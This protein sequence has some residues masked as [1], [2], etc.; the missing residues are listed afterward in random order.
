M[1]YTFFREGASQPYRSFVYLTRLCDGSSDSCSDERF[2]HRSS[3]GTWERLFVESPDRPFYLQRDKDDPDLARIVITFVPSA[4][5]GS[6]R[7]AE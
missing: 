4:E 6:E 3:N 2:Y 1:R 5:P 7:V